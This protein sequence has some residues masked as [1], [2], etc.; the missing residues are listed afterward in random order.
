ME[1]VGLGP[2]NG[3]IIA[4]ENA[5]SYAMKCCGIVK[6]GHGPDWSEFSDMLIDWFY[7]GNWLKEESGR[8]TVARGMA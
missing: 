7:S 3:K 2:E 5:L 4:E 1:Y 6:G 8:E